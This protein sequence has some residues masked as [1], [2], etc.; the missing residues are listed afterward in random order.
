MAPQAQVFAVPGELTIPSG[1]RQVHVSI[2][3]LPVEGA[4]DDGHVD[5]NVYRIA[6]TDNQGTPLT[7]P[8]ST[9]VSIV[10]RATDPNSTDG[11]IARYVGGTWR[12]IKTS[13]NG[14]AGSLLA[15][16][17]EFG[18]FAV[19]APGPGPTGSAAASEG[20]PAVSG[21]VPSS[22]VDASWLASPS[23]TRDTDVP[24]PAGAPDWLVPAVVLAGVLLAAAALVA[25]RQRRLGSS[26]Q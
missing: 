11:T 1:T 24:A 23:T 14:G 20:Q 17:R 2:E 22:P 26:R 3:P 12:P 25:W 4:P 18:D 19:I 13:S 15:V 8:P 5:G 7:A 21:A 6:V 9:H 16:V 10:L